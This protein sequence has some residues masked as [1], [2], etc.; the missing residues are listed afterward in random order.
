VVELQGAGTQ[1]SPFL[2]HNADELNAVRNNMS[3][4]Y[5]QMCDIDMSSYDSSV[6]AD[7]GYGFS[8]IGRYLPCNEFT[9]VYDGGGYKITN[10]LVDCYHPELYPPESCVVRGDGLFGMLGTNGILRNIHIVDA[11]I[12]GQHNSA[13]LL[14]YAM[15]DDLLVENCT[16][17]GYV[18]G[19]MCQSGGLLG[20]FIGGG[21]TSQVIN[22]HVL[23]VDANTTPDHTGAFVGTIHG[24]TIMRCSAIGTSRSIGDE[25]GAWAIGQ[26][27]GFVGY[28]NDYNHFVDCFCLVD[29]EQKKH[30]PSLPDDMFL[31][32][33]GFV[34]D[35]V[36]VNST[37]YT[38]CYASGVLSGGGDVNPFCGEISNPWESKITSTLCYWDKDVSGL[39]IDPHAEDGSPA[40]KST[41]EMMSQETFAG[42]DFDETW[43]IIEGMTYPRLRGALILEANVRQEG[44]LLYVEAIT[45]ETNEI[46]VEFDNGVETMA[47]HR[48]YPDL[49]TDHS[50]IFPHARGTEP[51]S[52]KVSY[53]GVETEI[54]LEEEGFPVS[55]V[56]SSGIRKI[57]ETSFVKI[58]SPESDDSYVLL[59]T[60]SEQ[61][62]LSG[63]VAFVVSGG[64]M[65][66]N[67]SLTAAKNYSPLTSSG[68]TPFVLDNGE[69]FGARI[70]YAWKGG[71]RDQLAIC[72]KICLQ[73]D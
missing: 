49:Q 16:A 56:E 24:T 9:G 19:H 35:I 42:W 21:G 69:P 6:E 27:G 5:L 45:S 54:V 26:T 25:D 50:L 62:G 46:L 28:D 40:P 52:I 70:D 64:V 48:V 20:V 47:V 61:Q 15:G 3:A 13:L 63:V 17:S 41:G 33:G 11:H 1:E 71:D 8:P 29:V 67:N 18:Y 4:H 68:S 2:V 31:A 37:Q 22:C 36:G 14:G 60:T 30:D 23:L 58:L 34:G 39:S 72:C 12:E 32:I 44:A 43:D 10:L 7:Y 38:R 65:A 53:C 59:C 73:G 57:L 66:L 51:T 55:V